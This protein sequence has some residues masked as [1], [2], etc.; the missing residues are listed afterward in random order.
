VVESEEDMELLLNMKRQLTEE[1]EEDDMPLSA[2]KKARTASQ[3]DTS[4][5]R[6][7][8]DEVWLCIM[9]ELS[10]RSLLA[11]GATC[12][13]LLQLSRDPELWTSL[14]IDWQAIKAQEEK[15]NKC[16]DSAMRRATKLQKLTIKNRTF[17]QIKSGVV[18]A[19]AKRA[20]SGLKTLIFSAEV[21]LSNSAVAALSSLSSL[22]SLELPGDWVKTAGAH[23]IASLANLQS[24]KMP[25]AEQ[26]TSSDLIKIVSSLH[27]LRIL[28]F[29]D[30]KKGASDSVVAALSAANPNLEYLALDE[31]ERIT[32]KGLRGLADNCH[33]LQHLSLD[34][35]Y[36]VN[37]PSIVRLA[38][39]CTQL[40][41]LS[42][43]LCSTVK[44]TSL[45][46]L[47][48]HCP[49]LAHLNLFGCAYISERG[50][51]RL[52]E[53]LGPRDLNY[54]CIRGMLGVGQTFSE[55]LVKDWPRMEVAHTFLP[56]PQRDR[57]K[58]F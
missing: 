10:P 44:D 45:K 8:P 2:R 11:L 27:N 3:S 35:C 23:A 41:Y 32:G 30:A 6:L 12:R 4:N 46:A 56:R 29:S 5:L 15:K 19:V 18:A 21:V 9:H 14:T 54:L 55:R 13:R 34:G 39:S 17:E 50:V 52:V 1:E 51:A 16:L 7:L 40:T 57:A 24:L 53:A 49:R 26:V 25:G 42:L 28:D 20:G 47:A 58:K 37:D 48:T 31:C 36:Q 38:T 43:G 22:T 33:K